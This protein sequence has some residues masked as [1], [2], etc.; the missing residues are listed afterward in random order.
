MQFSQ[1]KWREFITLLGGV[2]AS[3]PLAARGQ[4]GGHV[5]RVATMMGGRN[6][7]TD[8]APSWKKRMTAGRTG[9]FKP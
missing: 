3:W 1:L 2:A 5:R 8:R 4:Q 9:R 7:D 6:G